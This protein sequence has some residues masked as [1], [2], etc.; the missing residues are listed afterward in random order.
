MWNGLTYTEERAKNMLL[1]KPYME[2]QQVFLVKSE[3]SINNLED[4]KNKT[5]CVQKGSAVET[6]LI[7]SEIGKSAKQ[8]VTNSS[9]LDCLNEVRFGRSDAALIDS[10]MAKYYL[11]QNN[12]TKEFKILSDDFTKE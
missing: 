7:S 3:S 9:M 10:V 1:T 6:E 8:I 5:I 11:K 2:N 4:L 12:I